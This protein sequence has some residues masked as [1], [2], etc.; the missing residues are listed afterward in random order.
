MNGPV[1]AGVDLRA[2]TWPLA[3]LERKLEHDLE[4]QRMHLAALRRE[5]DELRSQ[6]AALQAAHQDEVQAAGAPA[7]GSID[8]AARRQ[9][10]AY[11]AH[12]LERMSLRLQELE[13][14]REKMELAGKTLVRADQRLAALRNLRDSA[15]AAYARSELRRQAREADLAWLTGVGQA[16]KGSP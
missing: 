11:L 3:A 12:A 13:R 6:L 7:H 2:F 4:H 14:L 15:R 5:F 8:A 9:A 16:R 1:P 10:L